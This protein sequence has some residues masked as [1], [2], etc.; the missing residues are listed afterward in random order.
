[1]GAQKMI[2]KELETQFGGSAEAAGKTFGGQ[3]NIARNIMNNFLGDMVS[4]GIPALQRF[5]GF[6]RENW[7]GI[8]QAFA[9]VS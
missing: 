7:P 9:N 8:K 3:I 1:M 5:A 6:I 2:L 4:E